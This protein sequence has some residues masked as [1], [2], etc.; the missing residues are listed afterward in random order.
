[1]EPRTE[2]RPEERWEDRLLLLC[3]PR[4]R[5]ERHVLLAVPVRISSVGPRGV[6]ALE[7]EQQWR[8]RRV[9]PRWNF[10]CKREMDA[11]NG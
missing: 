9:R 10:S 3:L 4:R 6:S 11:T 2:L 5:P 7:Q 8:K 1:M